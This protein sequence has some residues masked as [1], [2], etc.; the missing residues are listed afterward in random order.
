M[1]PL[2]QHVMVSVA[3]E[4]CEQLLKLAMSEV[5]STVVFTV[6]LI[7]GKACYRHTKYCCLQH[8]CFPELILTL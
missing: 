3:T 7:L 1:C 4:K 5:M 2:K 6:R 8:A